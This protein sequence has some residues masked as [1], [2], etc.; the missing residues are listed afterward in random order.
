MATFPQFSALPPELRRLI[1]R[2]CL[3]RRVAEVDIP[4]I[5]NEHMGIF[6]GDGS[7][8]C[9]LRE[10]S[11]RNAA[12]PTVSRVCRESR[13]V[14]LEAG[15]FLH[16]GAFQGM[17]NVWVQ[18]ARDVLHLNWEREWCIADGDM[19]GA[20]S[21]LPYF[22]SRAAKENMIP[23]VCADL[24]LP[25]DINR[26]ASCSDNFSDEDPD[27]ARWFDPDSVDE[28][29]L[30]ENAPKIVL[31][32]V[33]LMLLHSTETEA[34]DSGLFG[35]CG[36]ER[37]QMI[38][39][40]DAPKVSAFFEFW[41]ETANSQRETSSATYFRDMR[42]SDE[43]QKKCQDWVKRAKIHLFGHLWFQARSLG[44]AGIDDPDNIWVPAVTGDM[45]PWNPTNRPNLDHPWAI[46]QWARL[47][48]LVP[49]V[50]FIQCSE[51]C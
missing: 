11:R 28:V 41:K 26:D 7:K 42:D 36:E 38:D 40:D 47:P 50:V 17:E 3:P 13:E 19:A 43:F 31:V 32:A 46:Q 10:T 48:R 30:V 1:W 18:P 24:F 12:P 16:Y 34:I 29:L 25:F 39:F 2:H 44:F 5:G 33:V 51:S 37:I 9:L 23:S 49:K 21:A 27:D 8:E 14:A 22:F 45:V 15:H 35:L 6:Y 20:E 4:R